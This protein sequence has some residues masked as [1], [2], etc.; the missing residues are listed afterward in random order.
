MTDDLLMLVL[1]VAMAALLVG[2]VS[3]CARLAR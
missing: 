2:F 3:L 1:V